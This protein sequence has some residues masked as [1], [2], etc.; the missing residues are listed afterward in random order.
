MKIIKKFSIIDMKDWINHHKEK[1]VHIKIDFI[2]LKT[3]RIG[4]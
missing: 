2:L 3:N 1:E 4:N